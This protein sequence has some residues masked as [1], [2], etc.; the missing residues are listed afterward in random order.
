MRHR[1]GRSPVLFEV[2]FLIYFQN[3]LVEHDK[4]IIPLYMHP[5]LCLQIA[6]FNQWEI[7]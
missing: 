7:W 5:L 3:R 2:F 4:N 1:G 6:A